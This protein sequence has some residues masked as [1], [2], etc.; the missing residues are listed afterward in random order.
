LYIFILMQLLKVL[1]KVVG[2]RKKN[3]GLAKESPEFRA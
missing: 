3:K 2:V 1:R